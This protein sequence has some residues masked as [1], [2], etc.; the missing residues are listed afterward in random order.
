[1]S[2]IQKTVRQLDAAQKKKT[3][4]EL[5]LIFGM[6][7][8]FML[9]LPLIVKLAKASPQGETIPAEFGLSTMLLLAN[10][11]LFSKARK[12]RQ[13]DMPL[14]LGKVLLLMLLGSAAFS[15]LQYFGWSK[16]FHGS[17]F[18]QMRIM[19]ILVMYHG[20]HLLAGMIALAGIWIKIR[21]LRSGADCYIHFLQPSRAIFFRLTATYWDFL[22]F[23]WVLIY[24]IS[25][26]RYL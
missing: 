10:T 6:A 21:R 15:V 16:I 23:L 4:S 20:L 1:M 26:V 3:A 25:L 24:V 9:F 19:A 2:L 18:G 22:A 8:M 11:W 5:L 12:L 13:R 14:A 17:L 7:A